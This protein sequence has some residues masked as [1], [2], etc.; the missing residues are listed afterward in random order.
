MYAMWIQ[1]PSVTEVVKKLAT[2]VH[3]VGLPVQMERPVVVSA[4]L[5]RRQRHRGKVN[6]ILV[7]LGAS[8][9]SLLSVNA[10]RVHQEDTVT[11][12]DQLPAFNARS[13]SLLSLKA[14][15]SV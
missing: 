11:L 9:M 7:Q 4:T 12:S 8:A 15:A 14:S 1:N 10:F 3:Q 5:A 13:D 6:A 2:N